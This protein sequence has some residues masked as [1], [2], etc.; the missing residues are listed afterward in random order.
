MSIEKK[1]A[2]WKKDGHK[3]L[4]L[5]FDNGESAFFR[6]PKRKELKLILSKGRAGAIPMTDAFIKNCFLGGTGDVTQDKLLDDNDTEYTA[7]VA[8]NIDDLIGTKRAEIKK[9]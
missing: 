8:A 6:M 5:P 2:E 1:I 9:H 3:V 7:T 4:E